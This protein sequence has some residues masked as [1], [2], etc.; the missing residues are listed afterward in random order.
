MSE[1]HIPVRQRPAREQQAAGVMMPYFLPDTEKAMSGPLNY[2]LTLVKF[3]ADVLE[4]LVVAARVDAASKEHLRNPL[5]NRK[6]LAYRPMPRETVN[7][8]RHTCLNRSSEKQ[9]HIPTGY[10]NSYDNIIN[11]IE[12]VGVD[13]VERIANFKVSVLRLIASTYPDLALE[14]EEQ[15]FHITRSN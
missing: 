13:T 10:T 14:C 9:A 4:R 7:F 5:D 3:P 2:H 8:L 11:K 1:T 6:G 15:I 12:R